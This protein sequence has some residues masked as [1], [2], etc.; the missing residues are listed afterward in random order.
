MLVNIALNAATVCMACACTKCLDEMQW[1]E[2]RP[3]GPRPRPTAPRQRRDPRC[4]WSETETLRILSETRPKRD[5]NLET[6]SRPRCLNRDHIPV[7]TCIVRH[8]AIICSIMAPQ[9]T[10]TSSLLV[11]KHWYS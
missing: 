10:E 2:T 4:H 5:V 9:Y 3:T 1:P 7:V 6:V 8:L 11:C